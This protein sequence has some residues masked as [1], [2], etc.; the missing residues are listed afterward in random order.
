M[1][2]EIRNKPTKK[3]K[4]NTLNKKTRCSA[5]DKKIKQYKG[6]NLTKEFSWDN[7]KGKEIL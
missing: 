4:Q 5:L 1:N 7:P 6:P 3:S 2:L